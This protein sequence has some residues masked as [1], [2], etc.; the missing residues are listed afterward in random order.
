[1]D[2]D[3]TTIF[4]A[5][6]L[7]LIF[8]FFSPLLNCD[9]QSLL[10]KN[11]YAKHIGCIVCVFFLVAVF[12]APVQQAL[13]VTWSQTIALY[14]FFIMASKSK[15]FPILLVILLLCI[16]QSIRLEINRRLAVD[17]QANV[18]S[19][20]QW[21]I[22][23]VYAIAVLIVIGCAWYYVLKYKEYGDSFSSVTFFF[24]SNSCKSLN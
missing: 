9:L 20:K 2:T 21:R 6:V 8:G 7:W 11:V 18:D 19:L 16:D 14:I 23:L 22:Y 24:G 13:W 15:L 17:S 10:I 12:I 4:A 1:M 3:Y 5:I